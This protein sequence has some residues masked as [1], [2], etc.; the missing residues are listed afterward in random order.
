M[1]DLLKEQDLRPLFDVFNKVRIFE[2]QM[3]PKLLNGKNPSNLKKI[4]DEL[5]ISNIFSIFCENS[6]LIAV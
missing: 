4:L 3:L 5:I 6:S 1:P 2:E